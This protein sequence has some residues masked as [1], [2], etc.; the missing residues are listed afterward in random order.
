M[1]RYFCI[2]FIDFMFEGKSLLNLFS[3]NDYDK[4]KERWV[5]A[6]LTYHVFSLRFTCILTYPYMTTTFYHFK[7]ECF[8]LIKF[9]YHALVNRWKKNCLW[10]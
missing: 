4:S 9:I 5:V 8:A 2:A 10:I 6:E 7:L 1:W 3:S